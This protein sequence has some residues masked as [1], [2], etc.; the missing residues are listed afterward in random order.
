MCKAKCPIHK[1]QC[2]DTYWDNATNLAI[3]PHVHHHHILEGRRGEKIEDL[4]WWYESSEPWMPVLG[5][6]YMESFS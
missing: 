2:P 4:C 5:P 1:I 3:D 6:T